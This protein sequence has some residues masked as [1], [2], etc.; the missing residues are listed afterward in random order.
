MDYKDTLN[1]PSTGFP[2][3]ANLSRREPEIMSYWKEIDLYRLLKEHPYEKGRFVPHNGPPYA[4]DHIQLGHTV[5]KV[6]KD[7]IVKSMAMSGYK[8]P[9]VPGWDCHGL[10]IE[11]NVEREHGPKKMEVGQLEMRERCRD[12]A[13]RFVSR[14]LQIA[15]INGYFLHFW[16]HSRH[17]TEGLSH[18]E[19]LFLFR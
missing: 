16:E 10:P 17:Y 13:K 8:S 15:S 5:N 18:C 3:K 1:L 19:A 12:Y 9:Y 7:I 4:N 6:L 2:M 11:H 14:L